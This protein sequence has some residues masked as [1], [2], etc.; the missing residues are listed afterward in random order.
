MTRRIAFWFLL[1]LLT[2]SVSHAEAADS[3][4]RVAV[5]PLAVN[6]LESEDHL[7]A[8]LADMLASRLGRAPGVAVIRVEDAALATTDPEKAVAAGLQVGADYVLYGS[9]THFGA[10]ASLDV[11]CAPT[12]VS[13]GDVEAVRRIFVQSGTLGEIIPKLDELTGKVARFVED[14]RGGRAASEAADAG[15]DEVEALRSRVEVLEAAIAELQ[16]AQ[17]PQVD[18]G[19]SG[20]ALGQASPTD[21]VR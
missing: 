1:V 19:G 16:R 12:R 3:R 2:L 20:A 11:Q 9:F 5:L 4:V 8:G 17:V 10:G 7:R 15:P 14:G 18:I 21:P 6:A 13:D